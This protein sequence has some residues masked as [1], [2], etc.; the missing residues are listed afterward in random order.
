MDRRALFR[1]RQEQIAGPD[2]VH[3]EIVDESGA[4]GEVTP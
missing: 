4:D 1:R 2:F 3:V